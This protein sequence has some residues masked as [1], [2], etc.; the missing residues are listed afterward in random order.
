[1]CV[2]NRQT[3]GPSQQKVFLSS[4]RD[5]CGLVADVVGGEQGVVDDV[6]VSPQQHLERF[7][8]EGLQPHALFLQR[9][10]LHE[11]G[12][13]LLNLLEI[14]G[15]EEFHL[16]SRGLQNTCYNRIVEKQVN[17]VHTLGEKMFD[18]V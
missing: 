12:E 13:E 17:P 18:L 8:V 9:L 3:S 15:V 4:S 6:E 14:L 5:D 7:F 10:L 11:C 16:L 1:M 2:L